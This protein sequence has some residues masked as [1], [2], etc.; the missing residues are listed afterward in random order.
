MSKPREAD[1]ESHETDFA[2]EL[3]V[4]FIEIVHPDL[5]S[6]KVWGVF[7]FFILHTSGRYLRTAALKKLFGPKLCSSQVR[8]Y[9]GAIQSYQCAL[10]IALAL[11]EEERS[12]TAQSYF[13]LG[14]TRH[15]VF[16]VCLLNARSLRNK[17]VF[18]YDYL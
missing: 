2:I 10:H 4:S 5:Y 6:G 3:K 8:N 1:G 16:F 9:T 7:D 15:F 17:S 12:D 14:L 13:S 11:F 18:F